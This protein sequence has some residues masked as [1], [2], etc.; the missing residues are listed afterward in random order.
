MGAFTPETV[1]LLPK[2]HCDSFYVEDVFTFSRLYQ[3][4][5]TLQVARDSALMVNHMH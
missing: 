1:N 4:N 5:V 3:I 2:S